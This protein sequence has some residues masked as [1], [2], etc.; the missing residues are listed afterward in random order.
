[1][2]KCQEVR[3][4]SSQGRR[5]ALPKRCRFLEQVGWTGRQ[6]GAAHKQRMSSAAQHHCKIKPQGKLIFISRTWAEDHC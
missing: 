1:M 3:K 6:P 5:R 4:A 2:E